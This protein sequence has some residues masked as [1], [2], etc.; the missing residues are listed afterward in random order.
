MDIKSELKKVREKYGLTQEE[1]AEELGVSR[2]SIIALESGRYRPSIPVALHIAGFFEL[3][4][5]FI[6][7]CEPEEGEEIKSVK[8]L[9]G[10]DDTAIDHDL[11]PW[12]PWRDMMNMRDTID[13]FFDD[14]LTSMS[15]PSE[16]NYP[17]INVHQTEKA[18]IVEADMPGMKEDE[19][20]IEV[21][22]HAICL[23]GERKRVNEA[24][25]EDYYHREVNYGSFS[26]TVGLPVAVEA[27]QAEAKLED[28]T[29]VVTLPKKEVGK[30]KTVKIKPKTN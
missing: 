30:L 6:F 20:D 8:Q 22:D 3:P 2:Q 25:K 7:R 19:V 27:S 23:R 21:A 13:R 14:S 5:E 28:G 9:Q 29:L 16:L 4:V 10:G 24:K 1:L 12:S 15:H 18:V 26:R 17:A 11:M